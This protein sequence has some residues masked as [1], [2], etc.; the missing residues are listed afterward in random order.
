MR[1]HQEKRKDEEKRFD[2]R[3]PLEHALQKWIERTGEGIGNLRVKACTSKTAGT[4]KRR[5]NGEKKAK[6]SAS[7]PISRALIFLEV[8]VGPS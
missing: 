8:L 6:G 2:E 5:Q 7:P 1:R 3:P 4:R